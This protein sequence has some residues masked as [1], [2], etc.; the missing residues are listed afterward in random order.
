LTGLGGGCVGGGG[1]GSCFRWW[2]WSNWTVLSF[3]D[4]YVKIAL[5]QNGK[6]V[7][8]KKTSIKKVTLNPYFNE[9]FSFEVAF[10]LIQVRRCCAC[11]VG[12]LLHE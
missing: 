10:E 2:L 12:V 4:P 7:K 1:G 8:K 6:R 9:S 5:I 11:A 3:S